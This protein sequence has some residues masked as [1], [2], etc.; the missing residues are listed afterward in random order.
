M[1]FNNFPIV[2]ICVLALVGMIVI[3]VDM[4]TNKGDFYYDDRFDGE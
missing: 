4:I 2:I 3:V 1:I